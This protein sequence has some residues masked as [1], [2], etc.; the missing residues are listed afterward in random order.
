MEANVLCSLKYLP[1]EYDT[2]IESVSRIRN[3]I[4]HF[5][6]MRLQFLSEHTA[7]NTRCSNCPS[8]KME[9]DENYDK[10]FE[11]FGSDYEDTD[12]DSQK[13]APILKQRKRNR[14]KTPT[15][16]RLKWTDEEQDHL[17]SEVEKHKC[18]CDEGC[19]E[20]RDKF[21]RESAWKT[22][23]ECLGDQFP[24]EQCRAKWLSL[25]AVH[26]KIVNQFA[27]TKSGQGT[28]SAKINWRFYEAM[29]FIV[30][31]DKKN[32]MASESNLVSVLFTLFYF[33][34]LF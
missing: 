8:C 20:N 27:R 16:V 4:L 23:A 17:I 25:R 31:A 13:S 24:Q 26:R 18:L 29:N 33:S 10:V 15:T 12:Y 21:R 7:V 2:T 30:K 32:K 6:C 19:A 34:S 22:V 1:L 3:A 14:S 9:A 11:D 28:S 5:L